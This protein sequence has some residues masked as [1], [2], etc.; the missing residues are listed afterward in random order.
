MVHFL[1]GGR[2]QQYKARDRQLDPRGS[3][4]ATPAG[5][6]QKHGPNLLVMP[7]S[8]NPSSACSSSLRML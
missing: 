8:S 5:L 4:A 2:C 7:V 3:F 1:R 6:A